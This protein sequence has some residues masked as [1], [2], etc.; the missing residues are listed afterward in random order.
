MSRKFTPGEIALL[1]TAGVGAVY[2]YGMLGRVIEEGITLTEVFQ[3]RMVDPLPSE[4]Y[5]YYQQAYDFLS[6]H[7]EA[8]G[9]K[10]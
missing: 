8:L 10:V 1:D 3:K 7:A 9:I 2:S 4:H 5:S 6:Q